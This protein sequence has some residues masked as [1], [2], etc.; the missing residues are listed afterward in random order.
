MHGLPAFANRS[1]NPYNALLY[2]AL[3]RRGV[4]VRESS[5]R[6]PAAGEIVH[7][8]WP[9]S[10]LNHRRFVRALP[11]SVRLLADLAAARRRGARL[12]W[13]VH[14]L[15]SHEGLYPR[16]E[17]LFWRA[18]IPMVDGWIAL[19]EASHTLALGRW[20][21][22]ESRPS[23]V[24]P[25]GHYR[26]V[27]PTGIDR[28][29]ARARLGLAADDRVVAFVG[30]IKA[31]KGVPE[32]MKAFTTVDG[33]GTTLLVAGRIET[34]ALARELDAVAAGDER[35]VLRPGEVADADLQIYFAAS[36][37]VVAPFVTILNSGSVLLALSFNRPVLVPA[38]GS[39]PA[40]ARSIGGGWVQLYE[41]ALGGETLAAALDRAPKA[42]P[43]GDDAFG[44]DL[45]AF[46]WDEIAER[47]ERLYVEVLA[48]GHQKASR[49]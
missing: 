10:H 3:Q 36:D 32:L 26:G 1:R 4:E 27:Y 29:D 25:H 34:D 11:R 6:A 30:R 12:V 33:S 48:T 43:G 31:Y 40:L 19:N 21:A 13:T 8:H 15:G 46:E 44:P 42:G 49:T 14:N 22:L 18:V 16:T 7:V 9:E 41:G 35:I 45:R 20:P 39:M 2:E 37:L 28:A 47:T 23:A 38:I 17:E 5:S 24:V